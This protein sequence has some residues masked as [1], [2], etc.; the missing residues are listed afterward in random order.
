MPK[1]RVPKY[2]TKINRI[3]WRNRQFY[4]NHRRIQY[5]NFNSEYNQTEV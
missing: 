4:N 1:N 5:P 2:K 3:Q